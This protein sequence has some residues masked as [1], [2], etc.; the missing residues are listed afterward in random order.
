MKCSIPWAALPTTYKDAIITTHKLGLQYIW[1]DSLCIIQDQLSDWEIEAKDMGRIYKNSEVTIAAL[2]SKDGSGG[3]FVEKDRLAHLTIT[4]GCPSMTVPISIRHCHE[5]D[6]LA[7][8][9]DAYNDSYKTA[10]HCSSVLG[11]Y[12]KS[13]YLQEFCI[14]ER[15]RYSFSVGS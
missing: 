3:L 11:H 12:K 6:S 9:N 8:Y 5:H 4:Y 14:L 1:I 15:K 2:K 10:T 7:Y 13:C